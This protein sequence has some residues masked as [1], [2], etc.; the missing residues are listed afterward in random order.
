[1]VK[2]ETQHSILPAL[3]EGLGKA[4][5]ARLAG[6]SVDYLLEEGDVFRAAEALAAMD[7]F[8]KAVRRDERYV[9]FL[10]D[11]LAKYQGRKTTASGASI[12][13]CEAG[14]RYDY[15]GNGEW[16]L[17]NS[18]IQ[19]LQERKKELEEQLRSLAPGQL[20]VDQETGEVIEGALKTSKSTYRITLAK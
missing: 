13:N 11:E 19:K 5:I 16:R 7:E 14:V 9:Q 17:L 18:E 20:A 12:E 3:E 10:R 4:G 1:M 6:Q 8:V 15:S 2:Q